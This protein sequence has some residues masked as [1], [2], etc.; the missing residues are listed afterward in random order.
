MYG[1]PRRVSTLSQATAILG[2][3]AVRSTAIAATVFQNL[4][5]GSFNRMKLWEHALGC[6][7]AGKIIAR[8]T[9]YQNAEE[10]F[11]AGLVHDIGKMI[12][13]QFL[14]EDFLKICAQVESGGMRMLDAELAVLDVGHPH[15]GGW[16]AR[17]W[18][19]PNALVNAIVY[20]HQP[21][22]AGS[23]SK[24]ASIVNLA[25][26]LARQ[27]QIGS[28]GDSQPVKIEPAVWPVLNLKESEVPELIEEIGIDYANSSD[29]LN[30]LRE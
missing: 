15:I 28:G 22:L 9:G 1:L 13:D 10:A 29:F 18:N 27:A 4:G 8:R 16:L 20:H 25:D 21:H 2:F 6:A 23:D 19:L 3:N 11:I 17:K 12:I 7:V 30:A 14:N 26:A 5:H 24:L